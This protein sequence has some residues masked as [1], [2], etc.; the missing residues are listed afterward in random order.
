MLYLGIFPPT[1]SV[2]LHAWN[3]YNCTS[4]NDWN[5]VSEMN[6]LLNDFSYVI[7][8][9]MERL[10]KLFSLTGLVNDPMEC[11]SRETTYWV[12]K[13]TGFIGWDKK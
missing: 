3:F 10:Y 5:L 2:K 1:V 7:W 8:N 9:E 13:L 6:K 4:I 11:V 12:R